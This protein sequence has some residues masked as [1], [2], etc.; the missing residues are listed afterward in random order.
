[1]LSPSK[2]RLEDVR[3][4][5]NKW[6]V[7]Q[8]KDKKPRPLQDVIQDFR[9]KVVE[10]AQRLQ[11]QPADRSAQAA[12][13]GS[14]TDKA[15]AHGDLSAGEGPL[16]AELTERQLAEQSATA[17]SSAGRAEESGTSHRSAGQPATSLHLL[18]HLT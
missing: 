8:K 1:M 7:A 6:Q 16:L 12:V 2:P 18:L 14:S 13:A 3:P 10:A 9:N 17:S 5:L 4:L 15:D 11:R